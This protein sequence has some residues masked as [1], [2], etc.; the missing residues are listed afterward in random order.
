MCSPVFGILKR[1]ILHFVVVTYHLALMFF[2]IQEVRTLAALIQHSSR[3][4]A[5][6]TLIVG[7]HPLG[8]VLSDWDAE[9]E[10]LTRSKETITASLD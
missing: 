10:T 4:H 6:K 8:R 3:S 2:R 7:K 9:G 1:L 5:C